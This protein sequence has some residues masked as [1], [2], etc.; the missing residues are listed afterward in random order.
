[1]TAVLPLALEVQR[2]R[3]VALGIVADEALGSKR[4]A[5]VVAGEV[6]QRGASA[7]GMLELDVPTSW[8][9]GS[10]RNGAAKISYLR[11]GIWAA[12]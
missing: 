2:R 4:A 9:V 1:M 8:R 11:Y 12:R 7:A 5:L 6:A 10:F 3:D